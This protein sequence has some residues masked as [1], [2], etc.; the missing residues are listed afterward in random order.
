MSGR[1]CDLSVPVLKPLNLIHNDTFRI[2]LPFHAHIPVHRMI[3]D[4]LVERIFLVH[5]GASDGI[6]F[7]HHRRGISESLDLF[8]PLIFKR[9]RADNEHGRHQPGFAEQLSRPDGLD[10]LSKSHLVSDDGLAFLK[11]EADS[12]FL[13]RVQTGFQQVIQIIVCQFRQITLSV[14]RILSLRDVIQHIRVAMEI[15]INFFSPY[16]KVLKFR[17]LVRKSNAIRGEIFTRKKPHRG[18]PDRSDPDSDSA[19]LRIR[20]IE[21]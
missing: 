10:R 1:P 2:H 14:I 4:N 8:L 17:N 9:C 19:I 15:R 6:T 21:R 16:D 11:S 12:F 5:P 13:I 20:Q 7:Y 3:G 18:P